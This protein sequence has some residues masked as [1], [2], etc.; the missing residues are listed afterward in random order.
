MDWEEINTY[1]ISRAVVVAIIA[2]FGGLPAWA[3]L[4]MSAGVILVCIAAVALGN[5]ERRAQL[6]ETFY[7]SGLLLQVLP[8]L[9]LTIGYLD[10]P[11]SEIGWFKAVALGFLSV[12]LVICW[13]GDGIDGKFGYLRTYSEA[14]TVLIAEGIISAICS[15]ASDNEY[16]ALTIVNL[17]VFALCVAI[18]IIAR[19][20]KGSNME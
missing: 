12:T 6:R 20:T 13:F 2:I 5:L 7:Y 9:I 15:A 8:L 16:H 10:L 4:L 19:L 1:L 17:V 11:D 3:I 18:I 14:G